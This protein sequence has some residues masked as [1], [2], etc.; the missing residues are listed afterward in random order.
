MLIIHPEKPADIPSLRIVNQLAFEQPQ[1]VGLVDALRATNS[2]LLSLVAVLDE[3]IVG[4]A[5]YTPVSIGLPPNP[6]IGA[7]LGPV[8]VLPAFQRQGIGSQLVTTGNQMLQEAGY[9]FVVVLGHPTYYPRF[10]FQ[11]ASHFDIHC[12]WDVPD[13]AFMFKLLAPLKMTGISGLASYRP[14]FSDVT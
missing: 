11:P 7:G 12:E 1:E 9:P 14:E 6:L 3:Q 2:I 10:G 8:A 13:E 5:L 4:Q